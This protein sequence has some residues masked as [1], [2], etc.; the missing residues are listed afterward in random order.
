MLCYK[1]ITVIIAS[2]VGTEVIYRV[3]TSEQKTGYL[4]TIVSFAQKSSQNLK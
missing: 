2:A 1:L 4:F 3:F